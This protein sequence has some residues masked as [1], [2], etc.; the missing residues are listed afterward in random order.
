MTRQ[1]LQK[2]EGG[3]SFRN[4]LNANFAEVGV[5]DYLA[6]F[7]YTAVPFAWE[8]TVPNATWTKVKYKCYPNDPM[9]LSAT[10]AGVITFPEEA[11]GIW[12]GTSYVAWD[13][14]LSGLQAHARKQR[15]VIKVDGLDFSI[16]CSDSFFDPSLGTS[17]QMQ[18]SYHHVYG[19]IDMDPEE[20]PIEVYAEVWHNATVA[21]SPVSIKLKQ[22]G[23]QAPLLMLARGS[24]F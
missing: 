21:G 11:C 17:G 2:G 16:A 24:Y 9:E 1:V 5:D 14:T 10:S 8:V 4:K 15:L 22:D 19:Q 3:T 7:G 20:A 23:I 13:N 18:F 12:F 6:Y